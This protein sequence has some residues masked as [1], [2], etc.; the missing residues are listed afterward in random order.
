M[1]R[2]YLT[3]AFRNITKHTFYS[4]IN[5]F[6]MTIGIAACL[7]IFLYVA[8]EL[9]YDRFHPDAD[10]IY[11]VGLHGK[12][13]DQDIKTATTCPP[14]AATLV[15]E[16]PEVEAASRIIPYYSEP[17]VR[18]KDKAFTEKDVIF[19]DSNFFQ[20]F[21]FRLLEG[22]P[23]TCLKEPK[24]VVLSQDL[25][26]KYFG[27]ESAIGKIVT[28]DASTNAYKVTGIVQNAPTN[29]HFG[30]SMILSATSN[31]RL[32]TQEWLNNWMHNYF[33]LREGASLA[34][35]E[36]KMKGMVVKYVGPELAKYMGVT[37]DEINKKGG[38]YGYFATPVEDIH[39]RAITVDGMRPNGNIMHV[40]FFTGIGIFILII[41]C[42][43]FMNLATA[44][45][46]GRAK[47]VG[48]RKTL[49]SLRTQL[50]GQFL[51]ESF[52]FSLVS[53]LLALMLCFTVL[54]AFNLFSGK[55]L[56]MEVFLEPWF[57][58]TM[59]GLVLVVG[60][61][62]GSY[63][64]FYLTSF[65]PIDVLKGKVRAGV[66]SKGI[67]SGLV[68]FQFFLSMLL[69]I[70]T[71]VV[72]EQVRFMN[73]ANL[74]FD[75]E[76]VMVISNTW[77]LDKN[78]ETF[79]NAV[80][81]RS[82]VVKVSY[83]D[84]AFPGVNNTTIF[85]SLSSDQDHIMGMY[86]ADYDHMDV[87]K[88]ELTAGR[89]FSPQIHTDSSAI[90]LNEAAAGEFGFTNPIGEELIYNDRRP[91]EHLKII[92]T[93]KNFNF[94]SFKNKVRPLAIRLSPNSNVML[95]RYS[96]DP[97][98]M[99]S[100]LQ[101]L[102]KSYA[103]DQPFEYSFLDQRFDELFRT[104]QR[105]GDLFTLFAGFAILIASLGLFAL[106]SFTTEQRTKEI[107]IRK[108]MGATVP[109]LMI[110]LSKE[111]TKLVLFAFVPASLLGWYCAETWLSGFAHR[112][113]INVW[114]FVL[115][116]LGSIGIAW[117]TVSYQSIKAAGT[118]PVRALRY[119]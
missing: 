86:Y 23:A 8:D 28:I 53:V 72:F 20:F 68:V 46:A 12:V 69:I 113:D 39:L 70:F 41:A 27:K 7:M 57:I 45:S 65:N 94:E 84:R 13:G 74:G 97:S 37:I 101:K 21:G 98:V 17:A 119:E 44:R 107:G 35:V 48:L 102:W 116:G 29:A 106:A 89:Y 93:F 2:N 32:K 99:V 114:I 30:Y 61:F 64:A 6:G 104:E 22:D 115:S 103:A 80:T 76:N 91:N 108:V 60:L 31:D 81:Q 55:E 1:I 77:R 75:K 3:V 38:A 42:I 56:T 59:A 67:R 49:G 11:Q 110:L 90:L 88:I 79:R 34:P 96:G 118:N 83:T 50:I 5:I 52:L 109:G 10:R 18:Y 92:G 105:M 16:V 112:I 15:D 111:F 87:M 78:K 54:P 58:G 71:A 4:L 43:N 62:S 117:L 24:S 47:E 19:A 33:K 25:V 40:Y 51:T 66:K 73:N 14:L 100:S 26:T 82:D 9:S 36:E 95:V 85:R 63:P